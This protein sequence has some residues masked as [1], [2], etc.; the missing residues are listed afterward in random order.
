MPLSACLDCTDIALDDLIRAL[1]EAA[2]PAKY[3]TMTGAAP[4]RLDLEKY[5]KYARRGRHWV[6]YLCGRAIKTNFEDMSAISPIGYDHTHGE[7]AFARV[8]SALHSLL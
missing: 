2:E 1:W 8:V 4:P 5:H 6:D 3:F 7:G